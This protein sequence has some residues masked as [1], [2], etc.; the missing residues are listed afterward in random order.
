M[1]VPFVILTLLLFPTDGARGAPGAAILAVIGVRGHTALGAARRGYRPRHA[2]R[3]PLAAHCARL[4]RPR[5]AR[6]RPSGRAAVATPLGRRRVAGQS[7]GET[8]RR[9]RRVRVRAGGE[10]GKEKK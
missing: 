7:R 6:G 8:R 5:R 10:G 4:A 9:R 2:A 1:W 3:E